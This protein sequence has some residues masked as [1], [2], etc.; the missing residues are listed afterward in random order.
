M[1]LRVFSYTREDNE[2]CSCHPI[3]SHKAV[4]ISAVTEGQARGML[5]ERYRDTALGEWEEE[6][7]DLSQETL[8]EVMDA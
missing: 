5:L 3:W 1:S 6:E 7:L 4:V 2:S 8:L